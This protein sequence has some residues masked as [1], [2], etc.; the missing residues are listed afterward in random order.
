MK[1]IIKNIP[2]HSFL[3]VPALI[4]FLFVHNYPTT[5][6]KSTIRSYE[7]AFIFSILIFYVSYIFNKQKHKA[8]VVTTAL[9]LV[10]F[11]YGFIYE[12]AEKLYYKGWWPF[13]EIHRYIL[14]LIFL[15]VILL[16][17]FLFRTKRTFHSLTYAF[18]IFVLLLFLINIIQLSI[19]TSKAGE[20]SFDTEPSTKINS[21]TTDSLPDI[22]YILLDGYANDSVL[23]EIYHYKKNNLTDY[24]SGNNFFIAKNSRTNYISTYPSLS[25]SLNYSYLESNEKKNIIYNNKV[26]E[27]LKSKG[28]RIV[29]VRSGFAV[30]RENYD[31]DTTIVLEN[32]SEFERTLLRYSIF[33]LDDLLGYARYKT[34]KEQLS[35]MY[36]IFYVK[37]PKYVFIHIVSPHPPYV[38]DENGNFKSSPRVINAW[39]E[40]KEDYLVQLKYINKEVINFISEV[41]RHSKIKPIIIVQSDHGPWIQSASFRNIYDTRSMILNAYHVPYKWKDKLYSDITPVNSFRFIFNGLFNDSLPVLKD[42]PL[43]SVSI[44]NNMNANLILE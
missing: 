7:I 2:S 31:A 13:S 15:F 26:S 29:H 11:F 10:L 18:N 3:I 20:K 22:Y 6:F 35:V 9:M 41:F 27:Y 14:I 25:S 36:N 44:K 43:D 30:T 38:C 39:W 12:L 33:R 40:P 42:I 32:L 37:G 23:S 1:S 28:Y 8:G 16:C 4:F 24:L 19:S 17:Y 21:L 5:S 34:L